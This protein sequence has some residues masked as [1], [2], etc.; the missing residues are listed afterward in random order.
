MRQIYHRREC[1]VGGA[2][3]FTWLDADVGDRVELLHTHPRLVLVRLVSMAEGGAQPRATLDAVGYVAAWQ[4]LPSSPP[5][6][7]LLEEVAAIHVLCSQAPD[8]RSLCEGLI[9]A[10]AERSEQPPVERQA[11]NSLPG[12]RTAL[13]LN[14]LDVNGTRK[15]VARKSGRCRNGND[16]YVPSGGESDGSGCESDDSEGGSQDG[17]CP[18]RPT[19]VVDDRYRRFADS[20]VKMGS[21]NLRESNPQDCLT[22]HIALHA[23]LDDALALAERQGVTL[24]AAQRI[25]KKWRQHVEVRQGT[26]LGLSARHDQPT[27]VA[28][29]T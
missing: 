27:G 19:V 11:D 14:A 24:S 10:D 9:Y 7:P 12:R 26:R 28:Q 16:D 21:F 6:E 18:A 3:V 4:L 29:W 22:A 17:G 25:Q 23:G 13:D 5:P 15:P 2:A 20:I 1:A 8:R